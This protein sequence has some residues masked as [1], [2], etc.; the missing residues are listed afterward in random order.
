MDRESF[1]A[2]TGLRSEEVPYYVMDGLEMIRKRVSP[3]WTDDDLVSWVM[4][5]GPETALP[6]AAMT[7]ELAY[8]VQDMSEELRAVLGRP[9]PVS[10][11]VCGHSFKNRSATLY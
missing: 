10:E 9:R 3:D 1:L 7:I 4:A 6:I 5:T 8:R 11:V 2:A